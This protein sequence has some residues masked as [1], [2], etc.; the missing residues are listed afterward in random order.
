MAV[1]DKPSGLPPYKVSFQAQPDC[2]ERCEATEGGLP[3]S[4]GQ[5]AE[6]LGV[7]GLPLDGG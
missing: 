3:P 1:R 4:P 5:D 2:T 7:R 6:S